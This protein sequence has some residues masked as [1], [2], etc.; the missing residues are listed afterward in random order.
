MSFANSIRFKN[1]LLVLGLWLGCAVPVVA[2]VN[3]REWDV[4]G[5][6]RTGI[7]CTPE[8]S[9][10]T[11]PPTAGRPC[12]SFMDTAVQLDISAANFKSIRSGPKR[13]SSIC[14]VFPRPAN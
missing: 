2:A 3:G 5:T 1:Y 14:K 9:A 10:L 8:A 4:N 7:V 13:L 12:L 6:K 11:H